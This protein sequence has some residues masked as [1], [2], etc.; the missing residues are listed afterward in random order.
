MNSQ[1][2]VIPE[3]PAP[4]EVSLTWDHN[5]SASSSSQDFFT[6]DQ[7]YGSSVGHQYAV[8]SMLSRFSVHL[9]SSA[10]CTTLPVHRSS[11]AI[12]SVELKFQ[13]PI[14]QITVRS[15]MTPWAPHRGSLIATIPR[16]G[17]NCQCSKLLLLNSIS[18][19][20]TR[21]Q[22]EREREKMKIEILTHAG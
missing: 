14:L 11:C 2:H 19:L 21:R 10:S 20:C 9:T 16:T 18:R 12:N 17:Q 3:V 5:L 8:L 15:L 7:E 22:A 13:I 4:K 1:A 6:F